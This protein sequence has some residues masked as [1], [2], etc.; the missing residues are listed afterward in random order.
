LEIGVSSWGGR[1][2][3]PLVV[4]RHPDDLSDVRRWWLLSGLRARWSRIWRIATS[5]VM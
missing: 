4:H 3:S 5:S 1:D 2:F